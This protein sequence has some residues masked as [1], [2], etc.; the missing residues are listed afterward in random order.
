MNGPIGE[1]GNFIINTGVTVTTSPA[2]L[3]ITVD[4]TT[5]T[6]PHTFSWIPGDQHSIGTTTPQPGTT[7]IQY[8]WSNW[9]DGEA[10]THTITVP[11]NAVTYT[12]NFATQY[13]LTMIA[14]PPEGGTVTPPSGWRNAGEQVQ[15]QATANSNYHFT[16]WTGTGSISYTGGNNPAT[17]TMNGPIGETGNFIINTGVTVTTSPAGLSITVDGTTYTAPHT[18]SW[19]PGDQH[20]IG[21]T[22]PQPGTTGHNTYGQT[23]LTTEQ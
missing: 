13:Y 19:I 21:T 17:I 20:S 14:N 1:T 16:G 18:F 3:S 4:G 22:T 8:V 10:L 15:I 23:G 2:G 9:S 11:N 6:A 12:A 5:Y 7:G